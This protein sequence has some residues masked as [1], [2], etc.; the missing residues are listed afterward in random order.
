MTFAAGDRVVVKDSKFYDDFL[1][2]HYGHVVEA[3]TTPLVRVWI[4]GRTDRQAMDVE[5]EQYNP[6]PLFE[7][8]LEHAD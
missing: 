4:E 3:V 8:E 5:V 1:D 6:W 7:S 2:A